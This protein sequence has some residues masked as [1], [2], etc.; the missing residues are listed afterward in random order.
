LPSEFLSIYIKSILFFFAYCI[1]R[2]AVLNMT[3]LY[4]AVTLLSYCKIVQTD[5]Y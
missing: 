5:E 1:S 2:T 3:E 4:E